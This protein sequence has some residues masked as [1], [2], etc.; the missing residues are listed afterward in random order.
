MIGRKKFPNTAGMPG[1]MNRKIIET[2]CRVRIRLYRSLLIHC[3]PGEKSSSRNRKA[4]VTAKRKKTSIPPRYI[5][6]IF[7]WSVVVNQARIPGLVRR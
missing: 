3:T 7:L 4:M 6:P 5:R 1:M 2:P